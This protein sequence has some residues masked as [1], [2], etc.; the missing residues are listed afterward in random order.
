MA[1]KQTKALTIDL[2]PAKKWLVIYDNVEKPELFLQF[3]PPVDGP[4]I[5]TSRSK[6]AA[7][8]RL[9]N[10]RSLELNSLDESESLALFRDL[11]GLY[12][13]LHHP[14]LNTMEEAQEASILLGHLG[15]LP[16]GIEQLAAYV[17]T[18]GFTLKQAVEK[19]DRL[20]RSILQNESGKAGSH[21]LATVWEMH[22][23]RI[24]GSDACQLLGII[25][26]I[27]P[28]AIPERLFWPS[29]NFEYKPLLDFC[30]DEDL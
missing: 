9:K 24:S 19:Y 28:D 30:K 21:T 1:R 8:E 13:R 26:L 16:L 7:I 5:I 14:K 3:R 6:H 2:G 17:G 25:S 23:E 15:G 12:Q 11:Q 22:F 18:G 20:T 10:C 27:N 4:I 29:D